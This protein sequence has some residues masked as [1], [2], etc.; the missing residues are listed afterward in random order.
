MNKTNSTNS[1]TASTTSAGWHKHTCVKCDREYF[2]EHPHK[3]A[4][5][6]Q[7]SFQCPNESCEWYY[8]KGQSGSTEK[9]DVDG[10]PPRGPPRSS[11]TYAVRSVRIAYSEGSIKCSNHLHFRMVNAGQYKKP[12]V[13]TD[14]EIIKQM[15]IGVEARC[16]CETDACR[17][18]WSWNRPGCWETDWVQPGI[19]RRGWG[20]YTGAEVAARRVMPLAYNLTPAELKYLHEKNPGWLFATVG[21][22]SHDHPVAHAQSQ[23]ATYN[24][25]HSLPAGTFVDLNGN[26]K[27]CDTFNAEDKYRN[28]FPC[29]SIETIGDVVRSK[30]KWGD[31]FVNGRRRYA[32]CALRDLPV[33]EA[34]LLSGASGLTSIHTLYYYDMQE[35]AKAVHATKGQVLYA[36]MHRF[37]G[38]KGTLNN[39]EQRW[40]RYLEDGR[41]MIRQTNVDTGSSYTHKDNEHWFRNNSWEYF[42]SHHGSLSAAIECDPEGLREPGKALGWDVNKVADGVY[43]FRIVSATRHEAYLDPSWRPEPKPA[44]PVLNST[45]YVRLHNS[46]KLTTLAGDEVIAIPPAVQ[47]LFNTLRIKMSGTTR[48]IA[49]YKAHAQFCALKSVGVM[50]EANLPPPDAQIVYNL[51]FASYWVDVV[52]DRSMSAAYGSDARKVVLDLIVVA[53]HGKT[54]AG[55]TANALTNLRHYM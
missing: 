36:M 33:I 53:L 43:S 17:K 51:I 8:G 15:P 22:G 48:N 9:K 2:H 50:K 16:S 55:G 5:H 32:K 27:A 45:E 40:E 42:R 6:P 46:V 25:F 41:P 13:I 24:L 7:F 23:L 14:L 35:I 34:D 30:T 19:Y 37:V 11:E 10:G 39:G 29:V 26:P 31:Q 38:E 1:L 52:D 18:A 21:F 4:D 54:L 20:K 3:K 44:P 28:V 49:K 47:P 12:V